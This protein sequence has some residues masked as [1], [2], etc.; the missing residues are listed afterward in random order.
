MAEFTSLENRLSNKNLMIYG[1]GKKNIII[2]YILGWSFGPFGLFYT[3]WKTALI[4]LVGVPFIFFVLGIISVLVTGNSG[5]LAGWT[6]AGIAIPWFAAGFANGINA[7][8]VNKRNLL[9]LLAS[10]ETT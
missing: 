2:A 3:S 6:I 10:Q 9:R 4:W 7:R 8:R 5:L 1:K